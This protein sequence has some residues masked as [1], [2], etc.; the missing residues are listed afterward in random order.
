M[1]KSAERN[2]VDCYKLTEDNF[3]EVLDRISELLNK[4][5]AFLS[6]ATIDIATGR[7]NKYYKRHTNDMYIHNAQFVHVTKHPYREAYEDYV[8]CAKPD[9]DTLLGYKRY[10][11]DKIFIH[12]STSY[13]DQQILREGDYVII[14]GQNKI[15]LYT[16][17]HPVTNGVVGVRTIKL[18]AS[19]P[20]YSLEAELQEYLNSFHNDYEEY[21]NDY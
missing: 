13:H 20:I 1:N 5:R 19:S 3:Q 14:K 7:L 9:E 18:I 12:I 10:M 6:Y 2:D 4:Q 17:H 11:D 8:S 15:V 16:V 21:I